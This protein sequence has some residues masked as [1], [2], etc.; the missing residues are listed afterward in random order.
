MKLVGLIQIFAPSLSYSCWS[1]L[2]NMVILVAGQHQKKKS[3]EKG[4]LFYKDIHNSDTVV[5]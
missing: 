1:F 5:A 4:Q 3:N 2:K